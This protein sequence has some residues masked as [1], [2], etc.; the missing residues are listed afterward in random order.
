MKHVT[1]SWRRRPVNSTRLVTLPLLCIIVLALGLSPTS[2]APAAPDTTLLSADFNI[3]ANGFIYQ[4]DAFGTSQPNYASGTRV[5]TGGYGGTGGLAGDAGRRGRQ[6][7]HRHVGRLELHARTWL[8]L[9]P[10]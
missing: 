1:G 5:T 6:R 10:G 4:D 7:D 8:R 3:D 9:R 2:A